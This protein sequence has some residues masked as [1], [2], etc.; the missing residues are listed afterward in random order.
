M[1]KTKPDIVVKDNKFTK[2]YKAELTKKKKEAVRK[3]REAELDIENGLYVFKNGKLIKMPSAVSASKTLKVNH[4][5]RLTRI[6]VWFALVSFVAM[7]AA[8]V[9]LSL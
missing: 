9:Y 1:K 8:Q 4:G 5:E 6:A 7:I 3:L 2:K